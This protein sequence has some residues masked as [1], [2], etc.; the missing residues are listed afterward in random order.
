MRDALI[1]MA[2]AL[3]GSML[4]TLVAGLLFSLFPSVEGCGPAKL[5]CGGLYGGLAG[6]GIGGVLSHA[7]MTKRGG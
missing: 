2:G 5:I 3:V 4:L 7:F 6:L 1:V